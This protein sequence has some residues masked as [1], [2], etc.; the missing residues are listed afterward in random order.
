[1]STVRIANMNVYVMP[2]KV[3]RTE[4]VNETWWAYY[5]SEP[6]IRCDG[7]N[8]EA[9]IGNLVKKVSVQKTKVA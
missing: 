6:E 2:H 9:A 7:I 5:S 1:M 4:Q 8:E 3:I